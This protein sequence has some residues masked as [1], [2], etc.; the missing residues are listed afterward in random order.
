MYQSGRWEIDM[1]MHPLQLMKDETCW[2]NGEAWV[3]ANGSVFCLPLQAVKWCPIG[4]IV[5]VAENSEE[6]KAMLLSFRGAIMKGSIST[7][8]DDPNTTF[9]DVQDAMIKAFGPVPA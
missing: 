8:N 9:A 3:D 6:Q 1:K 5:A 2:T 4:A 7:W